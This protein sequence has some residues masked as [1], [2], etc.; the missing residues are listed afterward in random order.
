MTITVVCPLD[1]APPPYS[2]ECSVFLAGGITGCPNWQSDAIKMLESKFNGNLVI[3]NP[4]REMYEQS[5]DN[6]RKQIEWEYN[7]LYNC[8]YIIFWFPVESVCPI[9][10]FELGIELGRNQ[11]SLFIGCHPQYTRSFDLDIQVMLHSNIKT[12]KIHRSLEDVVTSFI[13]SAIS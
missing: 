2:F 9:A 4:R 13:T 12:I 1:A 5:S 7:A 8:R 11:D 3:Y 10:L 6:A